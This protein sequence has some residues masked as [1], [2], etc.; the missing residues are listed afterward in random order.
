MAKLFIRH[1]AADVAPKFKLPLGDVEKFF[2][3]MFEVVMEGLNEDKSVKIKGLGTFKITAVKAR[4]SV[5]VSTGERVVISGHDKVTFTPDT[6]MKELINKPFSQFETTV[7][8]EGV[9]LKKDAAVEETKDASVEETKDASVEETKVAA[10]EETKVAAVEEAKVAPETPKT[11]ETTAT[12]ETP[13]EDAMPA[14]L[15]SEQKPQ[16]NWLKA[17][18]IALFGLVCFG[19][20]MLFGN[21][22]PSASCAKNNEAAVDSDTIATALVD[23]V[24]EV[25]E[26]TEP[27]FDYEKVNADPR[28]KYLAYEIVGIDTTVTL[29]EGQTLNSYSKATLGPGMEVYFQ[30]LNGVDT[31]SAG[32][33]LKVPKV[34]VRKRK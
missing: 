15:V 2:N 7:L 23:S 26:N 3:Q 27:A 6:A 17:L 31:M 25:V 33:N 9:E 1:L 22:C 11:L 34:K 28:L 14:S 13:A 5:N 19:L 30:V 21:H 10:V 20:G 8:E 29:K 16:R 24:A 12:P 32:G 18:L 4:E